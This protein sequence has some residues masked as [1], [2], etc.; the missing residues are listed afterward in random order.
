MS[1]LALDD[2]E[3][4]KPDQKLAD[5]VRNHTACLEGI[6]R[7]RDMTVQ[8]KVDKVIC[9]SGNFITALRKCGARDGR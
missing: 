1:R 9:L 3:A 5:L 7:R 6:M 2:M 4:E 8:E